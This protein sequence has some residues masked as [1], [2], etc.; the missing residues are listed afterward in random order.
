MGP[1]VLFSLSR[2]SHDGSQASLIEIQVDGND[3]EECINCLKVCQ[4]TLPCLSLTQLGI[5][6]AVVAALCSS[7]VFPSKL[8]QGSETPHESSFSG[9]G[10][11]RSIGLEGAT[12]N[13]ILHTT[14][15]ISFHVV[16]MSVLE[17][18]HQ[19]LLGGYSLKVLWG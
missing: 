9:G 15:R 10:G 4:W 5:R 13:T 16:H 17:S 19:I 8:S 2:E 12:A 11:G 14:P 3:F 7:T 18:G 1:V 6:A